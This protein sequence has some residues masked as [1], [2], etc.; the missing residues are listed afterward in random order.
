MGIHLLG[1]MQAGTVAP[2]TGQATVD[3]D[4]IQA[5][6]TAAADAGGGIV[7]LAAGVYRIN[8][9]VV[10]RSGVVLAGQGT[11]A[12]T[13]QL[14]DSAN[15]AVIKTAHFD[16]LTGT[17][18][19]RGAPHFDDD[20]SESASGPSR[21]EIRDLTIDGN[22]TSNPTG[23]GLQIY[24]WDYTLSNLVVKRCGGDG[25]YSE[26]G[27]RLGYPTFSTGERDSMES[28]LVGVKSHHNGDAGIRWR[29]PHDSLV[30]NTVVF[31]NTGP[32]CV[33]EGNAGGEHF[34]NFHA[35]GNSGHALHLGRGAQVNASQLEGS[36][37]GRYQLM[38]LGNRTIV[39]G[40]RLFASA[41]SGAAAESGIQLGD[42]SNPVTQVFIDAVLFD[43]N[44][45]WINYA[46]DASTNLIRLVGNL[47]SGV[48]SV[49]TPAQGTQFQY[50]TG[51]AVY[52]DARFR[53]L[54]AGTG[55]S[56]L[57]DQTGRV[58]V[59]ADSQGGFFEMR[60]QALPPTGAAGRAQ[61]FARSSG[62]KTQ[63]VV[64]WPDGT[65]T[66]LATQP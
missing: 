53:T 16:A 20:P 11:H 52:D 63:A 42:A 30:L 8:A 40:T 59:L 17:N 19:P 43:L 2:P 5:A 4:A 14:A 18:L 66:V 24:G 22:K 45:H 32:G 49:G 15:V 28:R 12:T 61:L 35:W 50:Q 36:P 56:I 27:T 29:G 51:N 13:L 1:M 62:G 25:I 60:E 46:N 3:T 44:G 39:T 47:G 10:I 65:Q 64:V 33:T 21:F 7:T 23:A 26:W 57:L 37:N 55:Q 9:S 31:A 6:V 34:T 38:I 54:R 41:A 58:S 48:P